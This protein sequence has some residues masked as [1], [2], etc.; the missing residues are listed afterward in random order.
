MIEEFTDAQKAIS[1]QS[2]Q[3]PKRANQNVSRSEHPERIPFDMPFASL[4]QMA[5]YVHARSKSLD[6]SIQGDGRTDV[7]DHITLRPYAVGLGKD[8]EIQHDGGN[9]LAE[10][11]L[12]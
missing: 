2:G 3:S 11:K 10:T 9:T 5:A 1:C 7:F 4:L 6:Q 12:V 8:E